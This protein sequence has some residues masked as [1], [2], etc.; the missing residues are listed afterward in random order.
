MCVCLRVCVAICRTSP[1][2]SFPAPTMPQQ[3]SGPDRKAIAKALH[4]GAE[5]SVGKENTFWTGLLP[6]GPNLA[7]AATA[8][9]PVEDPDSDA[10]LVVVDQSESRVLAATRANKKASVSIACTS[11]LDQNALRCLC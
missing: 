9:L 1:I 4:E 10:S 7:I 8:A 11:A 6:P 2:C 5:K 3:G